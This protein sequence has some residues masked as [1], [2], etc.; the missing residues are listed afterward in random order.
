MTAATELGKIDAA[1]RS[2]LA[3]WWSEA[4]RRYDALE[5]RGIT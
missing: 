5:Q 2:P 1:P 3:D 4:L